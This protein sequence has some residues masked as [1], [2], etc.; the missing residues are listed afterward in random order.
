MDRR[1]WMQLIGV[2]AAARPGFSQAQPPAGGRGGAGRGP[3]RPLRVTREQIQAA[4]KLLGLEFQDAEIDM[5]L[6]NVDNALASYETVRKIDVPYDTEPAF[7]FHPGLAG[8]TPIAGPQRFE[9]TISR[10]ATAKAP[11]DL[12]ELAFLPV[13]GLAPLVRSRAVSSTDLTKMYLARMKKYSPKLLCLITLTEELAL[14]QAAAA[15]SEIKAG[16]YRGPLHGIPFGVKDLFDTKGITTTWGAEPFAKRVPDADATC[17]ERLYKAGAV[18]LGKLSMGALA[19]GDV[20]FQGT[21]KSPWPSDAARERGEYDRG[22]S[23]SSAGSASATAA[24]LVGFSLGTETLGSIVSPSSNCGTVGLRPTYG[25]VSRRGAMALSWTMDK[26]GAICRGVEDCAIVL[27]AIYGPDGHDRTV[28]SDPF[29]WEP[30][31][32]VRSLRVGILQTAFDHLPEAQKKIYDQALSDLKTTGVT[33]SPVEF[34]EDLTG[35]RYLLQAEAAAAFDDITRDG[36]VR[37]LRGQAASD[38]PNSF[39]GSRL[40]PAVEYIRAQRIRTLLVEK[41]EKFMAAWDAVVIPGSSLLTTTNLT[42]NPHV[43]V[44]CGYNESFA[45]SPWTMLGFIG[46][47]YDEGSPLRLA[48][49]YEQA[50][51]WHK[52]TPTLIA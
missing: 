34:E 47:I 14:K 27:N 3:Q 51:E 45:R 12:E 30:K 35:S 1:T 6:R 19:Q 22:S 38:W 2:L 16:K 40:I 39:R 33:L 24:G 4:L 11:S 15:D 25:R 37:T 36:Q 50:T 10:A 32:P 23:G 18:L 13:T 7:A 31:K 20:W 8:R 21:T 48:L 28:G 46:R 41:F 17:V 49:A 9:T 43:V 44:P 29:H 42:G 5:M 52:K 26:I